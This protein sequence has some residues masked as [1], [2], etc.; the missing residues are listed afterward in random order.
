MPDIPRLIAI[1]VAV[2][3]FWLAYLVF[4]YIC[5]PLVRD[6]VKISRRL[7]VLEI[8][9]VYS[10]DHEMMDTPWW[11][12]CLVAMIDPYPEG[13]SAMSKFQIFYPNWPM[14]PPAI[15]F[16]DWSA[17]T[18][19]EKDPLGRW[20][21]YK[22]PEPSRNGD[23]FRFS[24]DM[25]RQLSDRMGLPREMIMGSP[26]CC[27]SNRIGMEVPMIYGHVGPPQYKS[28]LGLEMAVKH[29]LPM[30]MI[31]LESCERKLAASLIRGKSAG[32]VIVDD[33]KTFDPA[34][35][36]RLI[37]D[38]IADF[39]KT[40]LQ[41]LRDPAPSFTHTDPGQPHF[42][43]QEALDAGLDIPWPPPPE[44]AKAKLM[45][46]IASF[47]EEVIL[48]TIVNTKGLREVQESGFSI[49]E[50]QIKGELERALMVATPPKDPYALGFDIVN[51]KT[52]EPMYPPDPVCLVHGKK[53]SEHECLFCCL[54][55]KSLTPDECNVRENGK[56]EDVCKACASEESATMK[57]REKQKKDDL[58]SGPSGQLPEG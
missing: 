32:H 11:F 54:C 36:D 6:I 35:E 8:Y 33:Y 24:T 17:R 10:E 26:E 13:Q 45:R 55:F 4:R 37:K 16:S 46:P 1:V 9:S 51:A 20:W 22:V 34:M 25:M 41:A 30:V 43:A 58:H 21:A 57:I 56:K 7:I 53:M 39:D 40:I 49:G 48:P 5:A 29:K 2:F 47:K 44:S 38:T 50:T 19:V 3:N 52:K 42:E 27:V 23:V 18:E 31:S 14:Q 12:Q 15:S 28:M